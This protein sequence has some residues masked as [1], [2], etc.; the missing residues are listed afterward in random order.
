M[1]YTKKMLLAS[2]AVMVLGLGLS[3]GA[4]AFDDTD[5]VW[6]VN[7]DKDIIENV[8]ID[9]DIDPTGMVT[10]E[11][12]QENIG[13]VTSTS[14][15]NNFTNT[16]PGLGEGG[17]V[18]IDET[19]TVTSNFGGPLD[20]GESSPDLGGLATGDG[21]SPL[22]A[23]YQG[24]TLSAQANGYTVINDIDINGEVALE[25]VEGINDAVDLPQVINTATSV[26]NNMSLTSDV[27]V[28]ISSGQ[29]NVGGFNV[30][31][32]DGPNG[33]FGNAGAL[34]AV[35]GSSD[36]ANHD[37]ANVAAVAAALGIIT[38]GE[39]TADAII[40]GSLNE[41]GIAIE[42]A[43]V[44]NAATAVGNNFSVNVDAI[45]PGDAFVVAD[46]TQFN[47]ANTSATALVDGVTVDNY[48]GLGAAGFGNALDL[49]DVQTPIIS[50]V[51]TAVGN[52]S[53][54]TVTS[55]SVN[56]LDL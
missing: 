48:A 37:I 51:A 22:N 47:Y 52:N 5:W 33:G 34:L 23:V 19:I 25:D 35:A 55:P 1:L 16:P 50:N 36:N 10:F 31:S 41:D 32:S 28:N 44:E 14:T 29:F 13:D 21:D 46:S 24:G 8:N 15:L 12:L 6:S 54:I 17:T 53:S 39:V 2:A 38:Q 9:V 18:T 27:A 45:T 20:P 49:D 26:A 7:V 4:N 11:N 30:P 56:G 3:S 43:S 42:N 40:D